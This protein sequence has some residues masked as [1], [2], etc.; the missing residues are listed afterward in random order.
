M[1]RLTDI[2]HF[3]KHPVA[4]YRAEK[5]PEDAKPA[6]THCCIPSLLIKCSNHGIKCTADID[7]VACHGAISGLGFGGFPN[8]EKTSM[9][10][11]RGPRPAPTAEERGT[12]PTP[13]A[14]CARYPR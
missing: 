8:R 3:E 10:L 12:S 7:H 14:P 1:S 9:S 4:I 2:I 11:S 13:N 5:M 6:A